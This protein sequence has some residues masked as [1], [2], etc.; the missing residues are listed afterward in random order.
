MK[1]FP[2]DFLWGSATAALQV[3]GAASLDGREDSVWDEF[4][5]QHPDKIHQAATPELACDHYRRY[6]E[7]VDWMRQLG[8]NTYRFSLAWPRI[9]P[10]GAG[11]MNPAGLDFYDRLLDKL[12][13]AKIEPNVTLYH[14]DLPLTLA[15]RGGWENPETVDAFVH[16]AQVCFDRFGDRV[17][18]WSTI[19][20]PAWTVL[21]GYITGL[22]P[23]CKNDRKAAILAA[24]HLLCAHGQVASLRPCGIALNLSPVTPATDSEADK[25]AAERADQI[26]NQW[27]IQAVLEGTYPS[28]LLQL[29][30][31][32]GLAPESPLQLVKVKPS[33]L[34]VN[35]YY[36]HHA[37]AEAL[38]DDFF[39]NNHGDT[40]E[41]CKFALEGCFEMVKNPKGRYT[42]WAWE[43]DP[44]TLR[45]LLLQIH[46]RVPEMDVYI[47]ENGI[48]LREEVKDG[49][50][51]DQARIDFLKE[52]LTAIHQ[53][54]QEG[55]KVKGYYM[56]A[57]MDNFSWIN[58]YKKRYGF[59]HIDR[60]TLERTPK[61]SAFWYRDMIERG[62][63]Y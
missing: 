50:V 14:W 17:Q 53:A 35:Y 60:D 54:M 33:F 63:F 2:P 19:N 24:H 9:I 1:N 40:Q 57:L 46:N 41:A 38:K 10:Q 31:E 5:R 30:G 28:N 55:V 12:L 16:Y 6:A 58:G 18:L 34:G 43:I 32:L 29:Y 36:P 3:E 13:E 56:W 25:A 39:I 61:K 23:P 37:R 8:H 42:D 62:G 27:F 22:H 11:A 15:Q 20:E 26:L 7:D 44:D 4:C 48:G 59:L 47:T 51:D 52:H 21:N 49:E 45:T